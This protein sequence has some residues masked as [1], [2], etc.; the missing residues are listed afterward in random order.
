M[1]IVFNKN[2]DDQTMLSVWKIEESEEQLIAGL[3]LKQHEL[4][5]ISSLSNGK[6]LLHWLSTRLLLRTMLQTTEYIDCRMDDHGKPYLVNIDYEISLSHS[7][8]YA[9]VMIS[10][11][12]KVGVDIELIK[13]KIHK[14]EQKFLSVEELEQNDL[15]RSTEGLYVCWCVKEAIYKWN[16]RKGLELKKDMYIESFPLQEEGQLRA[17]VSL[18]DERKELTAHYF[19]VEDSY[20]LGYVMA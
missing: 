15:N 14:I 11:N 8:D 12:K 2:I 4:D 1:P 9:A 18:A 10:R 3:Q 17:F 7:F 6:R 19:K 13:D 20:M 16:G 5:F